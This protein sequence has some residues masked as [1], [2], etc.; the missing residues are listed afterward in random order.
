MQWP[1]GTGK[2][3]TALAINDTTRRLLLRKGDYVLV[4]RFTSKEERRRV[5]AAQFS[6]SDVSTDVVAFENHL[7]VF[8]RGNAGIE[9]ELATGLTICLNSS[10]V[11][12][13]VRQFS[14]HTQINATEL[15]LLALRG[16][17]QIAPLP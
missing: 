17:P 10:V 7:D 15:R 5:A 3:P 6:Q 1:H 4:K 8:H 12:E 2:K 13:F 14:G 9:P 11:D 16:W